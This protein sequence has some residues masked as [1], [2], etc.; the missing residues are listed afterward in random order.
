[1]KALFIAIVLLAGSAWANPANN[2]GPSAMQR[3]A[4]YAS[5]VEFRKASLEYRAWYLD[6]SGCNQVTGSS[7]KAACHKAVAYEL[8]HYERHMVALEVACINAAFKQSK[9]SQS[10]IDEVMPDTAGLFP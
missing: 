10:C 5:C 9:V 6:R 8:A 4:F 7:D 3:A 2:P 1:M